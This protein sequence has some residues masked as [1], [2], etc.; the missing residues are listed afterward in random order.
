[1]AMDKSINQ[2]INHLRNSTTAAPAK[3]KYGDS[4]SGISEKLLWVCLGGRYHC[5]GHS[6]KSPPHLQVEPELSFCFFSVKIDIFTTRIDSSLEP[7]P[8]PSD[9][10]GRFLSFA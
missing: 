1:M 9:A 8:S 6:G 3:K 7:A 4:F 10:T 5:H 2:P